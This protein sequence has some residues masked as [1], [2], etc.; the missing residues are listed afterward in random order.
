MHKF[1]APP[2]LS[3]GSVS[4]SAPVSPFKKSFPLLHREFDDSNTRRELCD[5]Q[6]T[7]PEIDTP[8]RKWL[9]LPLSSLTISLSPG[10][11][12]R[13]P[14]SSS[15]PSSSQPSTSI[16]VPLPQPR[17]SSSHPNYHPRNTPRASLDRNG[18]LTVLDSA[19]RPP[20]SCFS[21]NSI[22]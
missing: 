4:N 16:D 7:F 10:P 19:S 5:H 15:P 22:A 13:F 11:F 6:F 9:Y 12:G 2:K 17:P 14:S 1:L 8:L 3:A 20:S 18:S 21:H